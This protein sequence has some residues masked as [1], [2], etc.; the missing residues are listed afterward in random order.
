MTLTPQVLDFILFP[1]IIIAYFKDRYTLASIGMIALFYNHMFGIVVFAVMLCH[2]LILKRNF[3]KYLLAVLICSLPIIFIYY[4]PTFF[5]AYISPVKTVGLNM[6]NDFSE[7]H[8]FW[9][10]AW[11][12]QFVWPIERFIVFTGFLSW[13]LLPVTIYGMHKQKKFDSWQL[14]MA[15]WCAV[16]MPIFIFNVWRWASY[17]MI[18]LSIFEVSVIS[19]MGKK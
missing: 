6:I 15:I 11:D 10:N 7:T 8:Q 5:G 3:L 4:V 19:R 2:S 18:P 1:M 9:Q 12:K 14:M 16:L 17:F 13:V